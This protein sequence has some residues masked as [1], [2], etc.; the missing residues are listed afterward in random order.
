[1]LWCIWLERNKLCFQNTCLPSLKSVGSKII[2]LTS[3]WCNT[4][5][6]GYTL[7]LSLILPFDTNNLLTQ[8]LHPLMSEGELT[9]S[10]VG[11]EE[12]DGETTPPIQ[13]D[14]TLMLGTAQVI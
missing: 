14:I 8:E 9:M 10:A 3:F 1:M 7:H 4:L 5:H 12:E 6:N 2:S 13:G 11:V